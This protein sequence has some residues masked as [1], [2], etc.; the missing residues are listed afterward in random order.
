[1]K[2]SSLITDPKT[3]S[4]VINHFSRNIKLVLMS[5]GDQERQNNSID[6]LLSNWKMRLSIKRNTVRTKQ[7]L[8]RSNLR[9]IEKMIFSLLPL[10]Q[11]VKANTKEG[12]VH[13]RLMLQML[14]QGKIENNSIRLLLSSLKM[15]PNIKQN[16]VLIRQNQYKER[17]KRTKNTST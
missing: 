9:K 12:L 13:T 8:L 5:A 11:K 2:F 6:P 15:E 1:M 14:G 16:T 4:Q 17:P 3:S 7:N 10:N